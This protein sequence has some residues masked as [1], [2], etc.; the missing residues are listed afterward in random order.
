MTR[1]QFLAIFSLGA[2]LSGCSAR[3]EPE[4]TVSEV[5]STPAPLLSE[6]EIQAEPPQL[7][8][9][10]TIEPLSEDGNLPTDE[11]ATEEKALSSDVS[12]EP[13]FPDRVE[14][15]VAPQRTGRGAKESP[16]KSENSIELLGFVNVD[17]QRVVLSIDGL[18]WPLTEGS[19]EAG[20]EVISIQPP[21]VVLQRGRQRWQ[22][23]L[24][25]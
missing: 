25:N 14:L 5:I 1:Y 16:D 7:D 13:P 15:F 19:Q 17:D 21:A 12:F 24:E 6:T 2:I 23:S 20:I 10:V 11:S 8:E 18:V 22:V 4:T 9:S 3:Q